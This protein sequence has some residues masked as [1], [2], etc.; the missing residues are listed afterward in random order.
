[1]EERMLA[2][3]EGA[4]DQ[5]FDP[6]PEDD[7]IDDVAKKRAEAKAEQRKIR[8]GSTSLYTCAVGRDRPL[9]P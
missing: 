3:A 7:D 9:T 5:L 4:V 6:N 8:V 1:M 2:E